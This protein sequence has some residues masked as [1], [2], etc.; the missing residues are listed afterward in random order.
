MKVLCIIFEFKQIK[1]MATSNFSIVLSV[2]LAF[3]LVLLTKAHS[4]DT[5]FTFNKFNPV[6]P[7]IILQKDASI[8]SSGVLQLTKVGSN[9]V[10]TS[11]SLGRALYAAPIQIWDSETGKVASWATSFKFNIFAPNKSNSADGL[12]FFLAPVGSQPQSDD[13]FLGL[14]NSPLKDKSLQTVAIEFDTFS[15]K[16]WD[17][18][19]RHI[20]I[21]VNSIK[22][23]KT[24]SW[25]LSNGQVAEILVTYNA[26]TSLLVASLIHPSKKTSYILSDTVNLKSNLPEWV[27]VGF[28]ATTGLHE[29]SVET[30]DVISWSFASK[31]SDGSTSDTLDLASFLLNEAI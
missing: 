25:G 31:L 22:S 8:S 24:A 26:A 16:K 7:N 23:V 6:Q 27:S 1:A 15:N 12:A 2:S 20:G 18:A 9:G 13:G 3:F 19:N 11:G 5:S 30:H 17:P 29:G 4:T 21:D 14:F 28:S 10:P